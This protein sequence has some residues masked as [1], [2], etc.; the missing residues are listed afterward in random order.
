M[1]GGSG[2]KKTFR[3]AARYADHLNLIT[4]MSELRHK[5]DVFAQRCG[6]FGPTMTATAAAATLATSVASPTHKAIQPTTVAPGGGDWICVNTA[7]LS[8]P[9]D[10]GNGRAR[11]RS[12]PS[13]LVP[14]NQR[15]RGDSAVV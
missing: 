1:L 7:F 12:F 10:K 5:L 4:P 6:E 14:S 9:V 3:L 2:E 13:S 15:R 8:P 11:K